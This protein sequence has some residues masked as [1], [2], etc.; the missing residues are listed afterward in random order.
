MKNRHFAFLL[1]FIIGC[2]QA[3]ESYP[4]D[5]KNS[6]EEAKAKRLR[7]G[8]IEDHPWIWAEGGEMKG[9]EAEIIKGFAEKIDTKIEWI[10]GTEDE[11]MPL[12]ETF[13][14]HVVV[15]GLSRSTPWNKHVG[16]TGPYKKVKVIVCSTNGTAIPEEIE[17]W[18]VGVKKGS[19]IGAYVRQKKGIPIFMDSLPDYQGLVAVY[20][21]D[22]DLFDC[23]DSRLSI[24]TIKHVLAVPKGE[25]NLLMTLEEYLNE[26]GY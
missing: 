20:E 25:N 6:L 18:Q 13:E 12:L 16:L 19:A 11:L 8:F 26:A 7:V 23:G 1:L 9:I 15:G 24:K 2:L 4:N 10:K 14:L 3:C 22:K 17:G 5:P 21:Y